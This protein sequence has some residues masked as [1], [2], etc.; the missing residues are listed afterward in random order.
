MNNLALIYQAKSFYN[1]Y[2]A[3]SQLQGHSDDLLL[4]IPEI[5]NGA[6][7]VELTLKAILVEQNIPYGHE[8]NLKVLFDKLPEEI[9]NKVWFY[10]A[11]KNP[12]YSDTVK[13]ENELLLMSEAFVQWRYYFEKQLATSFDSN[14]LFAFANAAIIVMFDLGYNVELKAV[15]L[16][17]HEIAE[18][19]RKFEINRRGSFEMI[20]EKIKRKNKRSDNDG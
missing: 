13:C 14:F 1:A 6:L 8:H 18:A 5:V 16:S 9:Q 17:F 19:E 2:I 12:A 3:L 15:Q 11:R 10:I 4:F 7:S 20:Q